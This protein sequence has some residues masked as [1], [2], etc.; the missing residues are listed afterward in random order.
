LRGEA[1]YYLYH[2]NS[3]P[4][5]VHRGFCVARKSPSLTEQYRYVCFRIDFDVKYTCAWQIYSAL[6]LMIDFEAMNVQLK[7]LYPVRKKKS[8]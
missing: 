6:S 7:A 3:I 1:Q 2:S 8:F 5:T 4:I